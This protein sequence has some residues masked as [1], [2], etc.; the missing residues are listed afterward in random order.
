MLGPLATILADILLPIL[1]LI[2]A[3]VALQRAFGLHLPTLVKIN[4]YLFVPAFVFRYVVTAPLAGR[5]MAAIV[6]VSAVLSLGGAGVAYVVARAARASWSTASAVMLATMIY[7]SGNYGIPLAKLAFGDAGAAVQAFV[8]STQSILTFTVGLALAGSAVGGGWR[9]LTGKMLRLPI[10]YALLLAFGWRAANGNAAVS[11]PTWLDAPTSYLAAGLVP[12]A[13]VTLGAQLATTP[14]W[15][16]WRPIGLVAALRLVA[17]PAFMA[18]LL[19][20][21]RWLLPGTLFDLGPT[22]TGVLIVTAGVPTAVNTL[23]LT[24]ELG[25]DERLAGDCV[26]WTT[27]L[28]PFTL[29]A[30]IAIVRVNVA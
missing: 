9:T 28:S 30:T 12:V 1:L 10:I 20:G 23:L 13:L 11:L 5:E 18:G 25:G 3:G 24:M 17:A 19:F 26:F 14:R 15:P 22:T 21:L 2:A 27:I 8:L 7:N 29:L 4:L 16:R 6:A